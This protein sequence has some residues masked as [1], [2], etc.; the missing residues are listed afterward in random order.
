LAPVT[1]ATKRGA[2]ARALETFEIGVEINR[3]SVAGITL[4]RRATPAAH[5]SADKDNPE[6][7]GVHHG[8]KG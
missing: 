5:C 2:E 7:S 1:A 3:G 8:D 6:T 4:E